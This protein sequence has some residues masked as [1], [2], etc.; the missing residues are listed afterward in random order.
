VI[1]DKGILRAMLYYPMS[2]DPMSNDGSFECTDWCFCKK[3]L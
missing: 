3:E 2:N 1:D